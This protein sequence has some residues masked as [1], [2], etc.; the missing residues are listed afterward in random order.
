MLFTDAPPIEQ[1][2]LL[3]TRSKRN[4][5]Y[6]LAPHS[7]PGEGDWILEVNQG[8]ETRTYYLEEADAFGFCGR[9]FLWLKS[10]DGEVYDTHVGTNNLTRSCTC[11]AGRVGRDMCKHVEVLFD[12]LHRGILPAKPPRQ[13]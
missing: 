4:R 13:E 10:E 12:A 9:R 2:R 8:H 11:T 6:T 7:V 5:W 1:Y 3:P